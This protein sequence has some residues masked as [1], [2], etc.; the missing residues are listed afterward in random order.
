MRP[1]SVCDDTKI[2]TNPFGLD[3]GD[4]PNA[5]DSLVPFATVQVS[6]DCTGKLYARVRTSLGVYISGPWD[7]AHCCLVDAADRIAQARRG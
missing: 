5:N 7:T 2:T 4:T 3:V 6:T 1:W